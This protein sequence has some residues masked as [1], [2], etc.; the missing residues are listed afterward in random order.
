VTWDR[1]ASWWIEELAADPAYDEEIAPLLLNLLDPEP[2]QLYLDVGCGT[3]RLASRVSQA[4]GKVIGCDLNQDLLRLAREVAPVIRT[5][6]PA[7]DWARPASFDGAYV[8]LVLEHVEDE[9]EF[10]RQVAA[11]VRPGGRLAMV[12]NHPIWT[13]PGS[14]PIED[15]GGEILWRTGT[16]FGRGFSDEP[17]GKAKVRFYHRTLADLLTAATNT[18]WDLRAIYEGGISEKQME[19]FPDYAGQEQIPR[20]L[21]LRWNRRSE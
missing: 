10:F 21:G 8:G 15:P 17:A 11:A 4:G 2:K 19:R 12:I 16:Y 5:R 14:T 1:L 20:L 18:G 3:G 6:L 9:M 13:A 7:L